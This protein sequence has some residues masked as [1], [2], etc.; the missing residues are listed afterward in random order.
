MGQNVIEHQ[1][2]NNDNSTKK[3]L[4]KTVIGSWE[5][6]NINRFRA[7]AL[8]FSVVMVLFQEFEAAVSYDC[9]TALQPG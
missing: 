9:A 8:L 2:L 6:Y 1:Q 5:L 7:S 4:P 3:Q